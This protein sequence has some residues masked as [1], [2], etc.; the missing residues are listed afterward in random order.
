MS[1][2]TSDE[3]YQIHSHGEGQTDEAPAMENGQQ[4]QPFEDDGIGPTV[5]TNASTE[6][7]TTL[8]DAGEHTESKTNLADTRDEEEPQTESEAHG[9][10]SA[11]QSQ[12]EPQGGKEAEHTERKSNLPSGESLSIS[13]SRRN[14]LDEEDDHE[15]AT[16]DRDGILPVGGSGRH[17]KNKHFQKERSSPHRIKKSR[18]T[19]LNKSKQNLN[20]YSGTMVLKDPDGET[21]HREQG[22]NKPGKRRGRLAIIQRLRESPLHESIYETLKKHPQKHHAEEKQESGNRRGTVDITRELNELQADNHIKSEKIEQM[23]QYI[24]ELEDQLRQYERQEDGEEE[25][26]TI[27]FEEL[28]FADSR[29]K[30]PSKTSSSGGRHASQHLLQQHSKSL[31][32]GSFPDYKT[33]SNDTYPVYLGAANTLRQQELEDEVVKLRKEVNRRVREVIRIKEEEAAKERTLHRAQADLSNMTEWCNKLARENEQLHEMASMAATHANKLNKSYLRLNKAFGVLVRD[34]ATV[35]ASS[36]TCRLAQ[37]VAYNLRDESSVVESSYRQLHGKSE[38]VRP[39]VSSQQAAD[40]TSLSN[41]NTNI[42]SESL[43]VDTEGV[44]GGKSDAPVDSIIRDVRSRSKNRAARSREH[45]QFPDSD[46]MGTSDAEHHYPHLKKHQDQSSSQESEVPTSSGSAM[47]DAIVVLAAENAFWQDRVYHMDVYANSIRNTLKTTKQHLAH[48]MGVIKRKDAS[49]RRHE[50]I[51]DSLIQQRRIMLQCLAQAGG[52]S[53][54]PLLEAAVQFSERI[55]VDEIRAKEKTTQNDETQQTEHPTTV[56]DAIDSLLS[57]LE[58]EDAT[59]QRRYELL[60]RIADAAV[61]YESR[62]NPWYAKDPNVFE[63]G[64]TSPPYLMGQELTVTFDQISEEIDDLCDQYDM[65]SETKSQTAFPPTSSTKTAEIEEVLQSVFKLHTVESK[66]QKEQLDVQYAGG[67]RSQQR[68]RRKQLTDPYQEDNEEEEGADEAHVEEEQEQEPSLDMSLVGQMRR[69][70]NLIANALSPE[71]NDLIPALF[72]LLLRIRQIAAVPSLVTRSLIEKRGS[73]RIDAALEE[74][75]T[76]ACSIAESEQGFFLMVDWANGES[77]VRNATLDGGLTV[78]RQMRTARATATKDDAEEDTYG[79]EEEFSGENELIGL[80]FS[81]AEG[82][83]SAVSSGGGPVLIQEAYSDPRFDPAWDERTGLATNN[84]LAIPVIA[85][86]GGG[87]APP[88]SAGTDSALGMRSPSHKLRDGADADDNWSGRV[89]GIIKVANKKRAGDFTPQDVHLLELLATQAALVLS[90][91]GH[92]GADTSYEI[93]EAGIDK[94]LDTARSFDF[95]GSTAEGTPRRM[96]RADTFVDTTPMFQPAP[97]P[98]PRTQRTGNAPQP[99]GPNREDHILLNFF[100][101]SRVLDAPLILY[102]YRHSRGLQRP[103]S[104]DAAISS[105]PA[106]DLDSKTDDRILAWVEWCEDIISAVVPAAVGCRLFVVDHSSGPHR[107]GW[108]LSVHSEATDPGDEASPDTGVLM[109]SSRNTFEEH[110]GV[111]QEASKGRPR[112]HAGVKSAIERETKRAQRQDERNLAF[113]AS[114][115][116]SP[117]EESSSVHMATLLRD[118]GIIYPSPLPEQGRSG[119]GGPTSGF[120]KPS[121]LPLKFW[122]TTGPADPKIV[123]S[124]FV[125]NDLLRFSLCRGVLGSRE[126]STNHSGSS[127]AGRVAGRGRSGYQVVQDVGSCY[128]FNETVDLDLSSY[129]SLSLICIPCCGSDGT[130]NAVLQIPVRSSDDGLL[131]CLSVIGDQVGAW[132]SCITA[133]DHLGGSSVQPTTPCSLSR[134][135]PPYFS[136]EHSEVVTLLMKAFAESDN[137]GES[138]ALKRLAE[139]LQEIVGKEAASTAKQ[140]LQHLVPALRNRLPMLYERHAYDEESNKFT[141]NM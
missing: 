130:T 38:N 83:F 16:G 54:E 94:Q 75:I 118:N 32:P 52:A 88:E 98:V 84:V 68:K 140:S 114:P 60:H 141:R 85:P 139:S 95:E 67:N 134:L 126:Y 50:V 136:N 108:G 42:S 132:I 12:T 128:W 74:I 41:P 133:L 110:I 109:Y 120:D 82:I 119:D 87:G 99:I 121:L 5:T 61:L 96:R 106:Q 59:V 39:N 37:D 112:T 81:V 107:G 29:R 129:P 72:D 125:R 9:D 14:V 7:Q 40:L 123:G 73:E 31:Q 101:A 77:W 51:Y 97:V 30:S 111:L 24:F 19:A 58:N 90:A 138:E 34:Q 63:N 113:N 13:S 11:I 135:L 8:R 23:Q 22:A 2:A 117:R 124:N 17:P 102:D 93:N 122:R 79:A 137:S 69:F 6:E 1:S 46:W 55:E 127:I 131:Q 45:D 86:H 105:S 53:M 57:S 35:G 76:Q 26:Y 3:E 21:K 80:R 91:G 15:N 10:G 43:E 100:R 66:K 92:G 4:Q 25:P 36:S 104:R 64:E 48:L 103:Q 44:Y 116:A 47:R 49:I 115:F 20:P 71:A 62:R 78:D 65:T 27:D 56:L 89:I 70:H 33:V 18:G 28:Y